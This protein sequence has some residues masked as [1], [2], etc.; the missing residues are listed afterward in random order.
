MHRGLMRLLPVIILI[1]GFIGLTNPVYAQDT[2]LPAAEWY[3]VA[4]VQETDTLHW[5]NTQGE[6]ASRARPTLT[7]EANPAQAHVHIAPN[8]QVLVIVAPLENGREGIGFYDLAQ[9]RLIQTHQSAANE[10]FLPAG[11][12]PFTEF[13]TQFVIP[14]R[15]QLSGAWRMITFD[16]AT[17]AALAQLTFDD[18]L[19]PEGFGGMADLVPV[20]AQFNVDE[21]RAVNEVRFKLNGAANVDQT[22]SPSLKW[23]LGADNRSVGVELDSLGGFNTLTGFDI[24]PLTGQAIYAVFDPQEGAQPTPNTSNTI[25]LAGN[26]AAILASEIGGSASLPRW[27]RNGEWFGFWGTDGATDPQ[28]MILSSDGQTTLPLDPA[29][30]EVYH[31]PDGLLTKDNTTW[32]LEHRTDLSAEAAVNPVFQPGSAFTLVYSTPPETAFTLITLGASDP[33]VA[34]QQGSDPVAAAITCGDTLVGR[35]APG[36]TARVAA[37][38]GTPLR[39]RS[40]PAGTVVTQLRE[41]ITFMIVA[42]PE[43]VRGYLWWNIQ[44][45]DG[46]NGWAAESDTEDYYIEPFTEAT[47]GT[48][49]TVALTAT[50]PSTEAAAVACPQSPPTQL[51]VNAFAHTPADLQGTLGVYDNAEATFPS[52]NIPAN[53]GMLIIGGPVCSPNGIRLWHTEISLNDETRFGWVTE[54][55]GTTYFLLPGLPRLG[56]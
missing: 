14:L 24:H 52:T 44:L 51:V 21:A 9:G 4:W 37:V 45:V 40:V 50:A 7:G 10:V 38:D 53:T 34:A 5:I 35:L 39:L 20:V 3:A 13:S 17:G 42:G 43:C 56:T 28:W 23:V 25:V 2:P 16:A 8:G 6:Q 48:V 29:V 33:A 36:M 46:T 15:N 31:T 27:L 30:S 22:N 55:F 1:S 12:A 19:I 41:G 47:A 49:P 11:S 18:P 54:G 26:P 32:I